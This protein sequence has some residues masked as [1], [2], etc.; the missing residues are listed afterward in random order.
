ILTIFSLLI[1]PQIALAAWWNP[2]TW[3]VFQREETSPQ[4]QV[5]IKTHEEKI[6]ELQRQLD[7]LKS[8]QSVATTTPVVKQEVKKEEPVIDN[9]V[10]IQAQIKAQVEAELKAKADQE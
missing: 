3:K 2:F 1:V 8:E 5:E 10:I 6:N 9:S 7:D 4:V